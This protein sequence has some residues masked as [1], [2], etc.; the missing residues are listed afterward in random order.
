MKTPWYIRNGNLHDDIG[1]D[2]INFIKIFP[3]SHEQRL[4]L[5]VNVDVL[6][7]SSSS[8]APGQLRLDEKIKNNYIFELVL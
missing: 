8:P 3:Q 5:L 4:H 6:P 7:R 1:V 2:S